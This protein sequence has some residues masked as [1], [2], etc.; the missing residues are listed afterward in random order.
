MLAIIILLKGYD[1]KLSFEIIS[2]MA[3][4]IASVI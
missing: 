3:I 4:R 2:K 1:G